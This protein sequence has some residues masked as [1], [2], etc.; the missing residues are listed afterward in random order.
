MALADSGT[1]LLI[2]PMGLPFFSARDLTQTLTPIQAVQNNRQNLRRTIGGVLVNIT[3]SQFLKYASKVSAADQQPPAVD[4]VW[5]GTLVTVTCVAQLA[6]PVGG[7][8]QR[9]Q[10]SGSEVVSNGFVFYRPVLN[11]MVAGWSESL[12]E[13]KP[14]LTWEL[15]LEEV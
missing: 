4:G 10:L 1:L 8:P 13:W 2:T 11:M 6:F 15:D 7:A 12:A 3:P 14:G 9:P 5:P